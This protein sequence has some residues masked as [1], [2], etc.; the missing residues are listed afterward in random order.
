MIYI[1]QSNSK[2][3][4]KY[5]LKEYTESTSGE[6]RGIGAFRQLEMNADKNNWLSE[7]AP[8]D[9]GGKAFKRMWDRRESIRLYADRE[10]KLEWERI[11]KQN[12]KHE[13]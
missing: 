2:E 12:Y 11:L 6:W 3:S 10:T 5:F 13:T 7:N 4:L 9:F 8:I 1:T